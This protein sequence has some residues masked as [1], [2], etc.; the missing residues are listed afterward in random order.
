MSDRFDALRREMQ[1]QIDEGIR[2]SIQV[3]VDWRGELVFDE[4]V[5]AGATPDSNYLLWSST[6]PLVAVALLQIIDEGGAKL[7][8]RVRSYIPEFGVRG[9][10]S[11]T[12]AHLLS[13]RGGFPD[14][15]KR[16]KTLNRMVLGGCAVFVPLYVAIRLTGG[17]AEK[18]EL[19]P[20]LL[21][22]VKTPIVWEVPPGGV[23]YL[24]FFHGD[25]GV[26]RKF[27]LV[28]L[29][30]EARM[31][32]GYAIVPRCFRLVD[33]EDN[34]YYPLSRSPLFLERTDEFFLDRDEVVEGELLFEI[35]EDRDS[36]RLLFDRYQE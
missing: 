16:M 28:R 23:R 3:A 25:P 4:A 19:L 24:H 26:G 11:C 33:D 14:S 6:K 21:S 17:S 27:V 20:D 5:G 35:P 8:D 9:K 13:H 30:M 10:E 22:R 29:H 18:L 32:I 7:R 34:Q 31:K 1:R 2:P 15:G 12:I 36:N